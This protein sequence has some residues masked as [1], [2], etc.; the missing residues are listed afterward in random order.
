VNFIVRSCKVLLWT[1]GRRE[2]LRG[3]VY[4]RAVARILGLLI[5]GTWQIMRHRYSLGVLYFCLYTLLWNGFLI[6]PLLLP[7][8]LIQFRYGF[9]ILAAVVWG[10]ASFP[11]FFAARSR[12][13][14]SMPIP[15]VPDDPTD[16]EDQP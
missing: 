6:S 3:L 9:I 14:M 12:T 4:N 8:D 7:A 13:A 11:M 15:E 1:L 5:P 2:K 10:F 16:A